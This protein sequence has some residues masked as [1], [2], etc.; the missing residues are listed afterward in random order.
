MHPRF[1]TYW[2]GVSSVFPCGLG[3]GIDF[4]IK[5]FTDFTI[6]FRERFKQGGLDRERRRRRLESCILLLGWI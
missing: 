2:T 3:A 1:T 6:E 4:A 5:D